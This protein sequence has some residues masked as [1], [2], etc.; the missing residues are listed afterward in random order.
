MIKLPDN[1]T[2][3]L[4]YEKQKEVCFNVRA[5]N[6]NEEDVILNDVS[7]NQY[8]DYILSYCNID[9]YADDFVFFRIG[10][11]LASKI[12]LRIWGKTAITLSENKHI[13]RLYKDADLNYERTKIK[14]DVDFL[15]TDEIMA[16]EETIMYNL[17]LLNN[18][19]SLSNHSFILEND[20]KVIFTRSWS[21]VKPI[22]YET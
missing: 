6:K 8:K 9:D 14:Y 3:T 16:I 11:I 1:L 5:Y 7:L 13:C 12:I 10:R 18:H 17:T 4:N 22:E 15:I 21:I 19:A 20:N 2:I